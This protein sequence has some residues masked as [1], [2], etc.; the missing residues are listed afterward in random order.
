MNSSDVSLKT[1]GAF[2]VRGGSGVE[3]E[4]EGEGPPEPSREGVEGGAPG[5]GVV[6]GVTV[7]APRVVSGP[8]SPCT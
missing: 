8:E 1:E 4:G 6:G 7:R 5:T 3:G 2:G